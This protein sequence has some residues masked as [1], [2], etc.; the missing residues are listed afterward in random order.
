[1]KR[2]H[3]ANK[4]KKVT[5]RHYL[6]LTALCTLAF[7]NIAYAQDSHTITGTVTDEE[8]GATLPGVNILIV[9]T[10]TGTT[11]NLEGDF[12][13]ETGNPDATLRFSYIGYEEL[14][15]PLDGRTSLDVMLVPTIL[16]AD[17]L[18]VVGYTSQERRNISGSIAVVEVENMNTISSGQVTR[19]LQGSA[20]GVTVVSSGQPGSSPKVRIRGINTFGDDTPL[21]IVDGVP[22]QNIENLNPQDIQS[23]S[24]LKDAASASI[25]GARA[26]NGVI[27]ITTQRGEGAVQVNYNGYAGYD[28]P[29]RG[30][31]WNL[32]NPQEMAELRW[33]AIE[34]SGGDPRPDPQYGSGSE[35]VLPDYLMPAGRMEGEVDHD[36]YY[37]I[38]EYT[39]PAQLSTFNQIVRANPNGTNWYEEIFSPA[40]SM[41]HDISVSGG[42][43]QGNFYVSVNHL[44][45]QGTLK[46]T[47]NRRSTIRANSQFNVSE[48][49]RIGENLAFSQ[50]NN[51][52]VGTLT[53][54]SA[55]GMSFRQQPII[56]VYDI[57]GNYAGSAPTNMGNAHN[58]LALLD[59]MANNRTDVSRLFGNAF[60][61]FDF[62]NHLSFR[63]S[64]GGDLRSISRRSFS[65]PSYERSENSTTNS[66]SASSDY[67]Q[68][69]NWSNVLTYQQEIANLH[70]LEIMAG[71][72]AFRARGQDV[73]GTTQ[74]YFSFNPNYT[75]LTTGSGTRTNFSE[76]YQNSLLSFFGSINY[77][78]DS[79][80]ILSATIRHD[81]SSRFDRNKWGTFPA[82][83]VAWRLTQESFMENRFSWLSDLRLRAGIGVMGNEMNV[84]A[85]NPYTLFA[86]NQSSSYYPIDGSNSQIALGFE[87]DRIGNPNA[88]WEK[89]VTGNIG[90]DAILFSDRVELSAEYYWK[91]VTDLLYNPELPGTAGAA[92]QPFVN[93]A[94]MQ[95]RGIDASINARGNI[96]TQMQYRAGVNVTS[97]RNEIIK[98]SEGIDYFTQDGRRFSG[99]AIIR[100]EVGQPV[101][102]FYGYKIAGFWNSQSEIDEANTSSPS[103]TYQTDVAVGR[104]R[105]A[106]IDGDGEITPDDRT[107]LG[108][109]NPD[110][111]YGINLGLDYRNFDFTAFFYGSQ[112]NDIWNNVKWWTDFYSNFEGA[113]SKRALYDS[114]TPENQNASLPIQDTGGGFSSSTVP[115]SYF[116][117]DGS[118]LRL[119]TVVIGYSLPVGVTGAI[120][121][122]R[123][124]IYLQGSN[125][126]TLTGYDGLDPEIGGG[127]TN[128]GIDEGA[129]APARQI[130]LGLNL[131]F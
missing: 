118:Y 120:G 83:S 1:M 69:W 49:F 131:S 55:I 51:P 45:Q 53:E 76:N 66:F 125:L 129:Y 113:K 116:V 97:Y 93:V 87:Q 31:V 130:L 27:V 60:V 26:A 98:I 79:R 65:Y 80:Y 127:N 115:N 72:E 117:E 90:F 91:D 67:R 94:N 114:W 36:S 92:S 37:L 9:G 14:E 38:P 2:E 99:S 89:N 86:G 85:N 5:M 22:T 88:R 104:Y 19:G 101:S 43:E 111:T 28:I 7:I 54:G 29:H 119:R 100:N 35:P 40:L 112:G 95:N 64:F 52:T 126:F 71:T 84:N 33:R 11:T 18:V 121:A 24:V 102:S 21:Y 62:L 70:N 59:R 13:L 107:F 75:N 50:T 77:N 58:P 103:G 25:Y 46:N 105:Y 73:G 74:G 47:Y 39:D 12:E 16:S 3:S 17:E 81:G 44:D 42:G 109:P 110:F 128:Y 41:N 34:N 123:A 8:T 96:G 32:L 30:N 82:A 124:R 4:K 108:D 20:S 61:E 68:E 56:P 63:S 15:I 10:S 57:M 122:S 6:W 48:N 106:D 23:M 78:Y